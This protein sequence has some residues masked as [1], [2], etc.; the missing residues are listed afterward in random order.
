LIPKRRR[1]PRAAAE[2][3]APST[4][5]NSRGLQLRSLAFIIYGRGHLFERVPIFPPSTVQ[6]FFIDCKIRKKKKE[7]K[8]KEKKK[9]WNS[10][11]SLMSYPPSLLTYLL[12]FFL[13]LLLTHHPWLKHGS[14]FSS[15]CSLSR[16]DASSNAQQQLP[17]PHLC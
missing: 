3:K 16:L 8:E 7:K 2:K 9:S 6:D 13:M 12:L 14:T 4:P 17:Q 11:V 5:V 1:R 10:H 15:L